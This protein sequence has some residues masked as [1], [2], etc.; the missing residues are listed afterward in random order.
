MPNGVKDEVSDDGKLIKRV[1]NRYVLQ[2]SDFIQL[3]TS[4][5]TNTDIVYVDA[6]VFNNADKTNW[7]N[8]VIANN[9]D[10]FGYYETDYADDV[11]KVGKFYTSSTGTIGFIV[12][13]GQYADLTEAQ[14]DLAG[15]T[16]I[17]QLEQEEVHDLN[18][19]PLNSYPNGTLIVEPY[20]RK[21]LKYDAITG[22]GLDFPVVLSSIEKIEDVNG[23]EI[24]LA[25]VTLASDGLSATIT[26]ANDNDVYVVY[27]LPREGVIPT[28]TYKVPLNTSATIKDNN[29]M[30]Q[31]HSKNILDLQDQVAMLIVLNS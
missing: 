17:Y 30:I 10:V 1:S 11:N 3:N 5:G 9:I 29:A 15:T 21:S 8:S 4:L 19:P 2:A 12:A 7:F 25:N 26:G 20:L 13:K 16:L 18:I 27:G 6:N 14:A 24:D 31:Q 22:N 28:V 23:N